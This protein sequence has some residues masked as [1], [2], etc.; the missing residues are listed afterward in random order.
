MSESF[1]FERRFCDVVWRQL[2]TCAMM[3]VA[4]G[5]ISAKALPQWSAEDRA[6]LN[7]GEIVAGASLLVD[8]TPRRTASGEVVAPVF[9]VVPI[10]PVE[11]T[12]PVVDA[13][14]RHIPEE[15]LGDYFTKAP[16]TYL[17]DPQRLFSNQE[18]LDREGFLEYY[19][20]ESE[21]DVRIYLFDAEQQIPS[22]YTLQ[23]LVENQYSKGPLTAVVFYF[24]GNPKRNQ[25]LFG[26]LGADLVDSERLR[27]MLGSAKI[28][29]MEKSDSAAQMESFIVQLSIS[30]YWM[31]QSIAETHAADV[32]APSS[33][34]ESEKSA[35]KR[36]TGFEKIQPYLWYG[37]I[38]VL[39]VLMAGFALIRAW[40]LWSRS[41]RYYFPILELP[42]RLGAD[43]AA[44]IG[45]V[46]GFHNKLDSP[47]SQRDQI[48]EYLTKL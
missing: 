3:L 34:Q 22:D 7:K 5:G 14:A 23:Q 16:E 20:D 32:T 2:A 29:A 6:R 41:R 13:A 33:A 28:K 38:G 10:P 45:S 24:L 36:G 9:P 40:V 12:P 35:S 27:K 37:A 47:S 48:P 39:S 19:A 18:T 17:I 31:E 11:P 1:L 15:Y 42:P 44:G 21:V 25:L 30:I 8:S 43:Y 26:G 46:I 4:C